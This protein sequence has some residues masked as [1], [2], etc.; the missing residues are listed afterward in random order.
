MEHT[1][2]LAE[3]SAVKFHQNLKA[4]MDLAMILY[5]FQMVIKKL[6]VKLSLI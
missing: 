1:K 2:H 4:K 5:L 6:L 3:L